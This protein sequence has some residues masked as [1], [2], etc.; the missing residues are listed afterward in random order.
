MVALGN[1]PACI[2]ARS[3]RSTYPTAVEAFD[4]VEAGA[5]VLFTLGG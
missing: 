2:T 3:K 4:S 5:G 1:W